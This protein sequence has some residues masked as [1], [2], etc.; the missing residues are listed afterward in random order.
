[1]LD[2]AHFRHVEAEEDGGLVPLETLHAFASLLAEVGC[3]LCF[4]EGQPP[5]Q[6]VSL[7]FGCVGVQVKV[8]GN[9][10]PALLAAAALH[11]GGLQRQLHC[12]V[13]LHRRLRWGQQL[14]LLSLLAHGRPLFSLTFVHLDDLL[15]CSF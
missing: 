7:G 5:A 8:F 3:Q 1:M 13:A 9:E 2:F 14:L 12:G 11:R 15:Q 4:G 6:L 10:V